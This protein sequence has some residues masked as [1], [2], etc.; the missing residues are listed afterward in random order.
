VTEELVPLDERIRLVELV[1]RVLDKG[2]VLHGDI[3]I[4]VAG[5]DLVYLELQLLLASVES[6]ARRQGGASE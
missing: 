5:V 3:V 4:S 2:V 1:D 6:L